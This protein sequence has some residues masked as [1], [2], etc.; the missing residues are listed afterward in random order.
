MNKIFHSTLGPESI[1][2]K[3]EPKGR[4][5]PKRSLKSDP[6]S[7]LKNHQVELDHQSC[8]SPSHG[9]RGSPPQGGQPLLLQV[10]RQF[11][12]NT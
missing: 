9:W 6:D 8:Q 10:P 11:W 5:R 12:M 4:I 7:D 3:D 1:T 2:S